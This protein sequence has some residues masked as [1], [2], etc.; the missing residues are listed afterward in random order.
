MQDKGPQWWGTRRNAVSTV[1]LTFKSSPAWAISSGLDQ[2]TSQSLLQIR[3]TNCSDLYLSLGFPGGAKGKEPA[4][5]CRRLKRQEFDPWLG[6][7]HWRRTR[8]PFSSTLVWRIPWTEEPGGLQSRGS[9][10]VRHDWSNL[11]CMQEK[12]NT[13]YFECVCRSFTSWSGFS[14]FWWLRQDQLVRVHCFL[15]L[16]V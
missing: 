1:H 3:L 8:Q 15:N 16:Q 4:L 2:Y 7:I 9:Q 14:F 12:S 6:K 13:F 11:A 5:Q 10:R